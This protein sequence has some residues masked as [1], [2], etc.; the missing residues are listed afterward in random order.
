MGRQ[1]RQGRNRQDQEYTRVTRT[2]GRREKDNPAKDNG[3][4]G[5]GVRHETLTRQEWL[6]AG[7]GNEAIKETGVSEGR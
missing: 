3:K 2:T 4:S 7:E 5:T 6:R 1:G